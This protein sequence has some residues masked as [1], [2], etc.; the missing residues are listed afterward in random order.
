M[1]AWHRCDTRY[2][3]ARPQELIMSAGQR[4]GCV[5]I[6]MLAG[7]AGL[8]FP[9]ARASAQQMRFMATAGPGGGGSGQISKRSM[10]RYAEL[11]NLTAEQ[12]ESAMA[13]HEGY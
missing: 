6:V 10:E 9:A 11:L 12:K 13:I 5:G 7:M 1:A 4:L 3:R 2:T 8:A